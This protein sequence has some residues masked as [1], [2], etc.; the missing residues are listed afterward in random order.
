MKYCTFF[1]HHDCPDSIKPKL[2]EAIREQIVNGVGGFYVGTHGH[3]DTIVL[4]CLRELKKEY[5][6]ITYAVVFAYLPK[7]ND[8]YTPGETV[9]PEGIES[10]PDRFAIDF[11]NRW[12][13]D[14]ADTVI[15]YTTHAWG[16]AAKYVQNAKR[17]GKTVVRVE[18]SDLIRDKP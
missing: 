2:K 5:P 11:R 14:H 4:F 1:G 12:M 8:I 9:L 18:S 10:V 7:D 16:G 6:G 3:F 15:A 17:K 13:L